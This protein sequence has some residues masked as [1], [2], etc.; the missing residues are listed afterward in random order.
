ME[1]FLAYT[2]LGVALGSVYAIAATG[3]V[4]TY[5]T[6]GIFNFAHGAIGMLSGLFYWQLRIGWDWPAPLAIVATVFVFAPAVG[7]LL[8]FLVMRH[9]QGTSEVTRLVVPVA[10]LLALN[11]AATWVWFRK[12][13]VSHN[14]VEF[15]GDRKVSVFGQPLLWHQIIGMAAAA[16][17]AVALWAFLYHTRLGVTMRATVDDRALLML[18]GGRPDRMS[19]ASWAIGAG[20]AGLAGVLLSPQLGELQVFALTLLVFDA[21]PAAIAGRL[22]S[23]PLAY[24]GAIALGLAKLYFDWLSQA[25]SRWPAFGNL[26]IALPA[27]LLFVVLLILPQERLRGAV[28][29]RTREEFRVPTLG[30][31]LLWGGL[32]ILGVG[33]LQAVMHD[34]AVI[35]LANAMGLALMALSLVLLTGY[36][37][38]VNLAVF[39]F[40]GI[41]LIAMWQFEVGPGGT[42]T[43]E[44]MSLAG[45]ALAM[46]VC[47]VVGGLIALPALRLRGLYL[48][49]ATFAFAIV[50]TQLVIFQINPLHFEILG[51]RFELNLF[52]T[53]SLT[54]P[55]PHWFGIDFA[56]S[57]RAYLMLMTALFS[58]LGVALVALRRSSYGRV[59]AAMKDSPAACATLGLNIVRMKLSVFMLSSALAGLGGLMWAA[60]QRQLSNQGSFDVFVSLS[61]FMLTVVGGIGYVSGAL[62][63][64]VFMSVLG[65]VIPDIFHKLGSDYPTLDWL[66]EGALGNFTK[67]LGPA[68]L[69]I[70]LGRHPA[71]VASQLMD[72]FRP[73]RR[74]PGGVA[75]W[76]VGELLIWSLAWR[77]VIGN[78]TFA[79]LT[80]AG[81]FVVPRLIM[82]ADRARFAE[83][84]P[85]S[86]AEELD[87]LGLERPFTVADRER[88]DS[89]LGLGLVRTE[90]GSRAVARMS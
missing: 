83:V 43:R 88:L 36:A 54:V 70:G 37:G 82:A 66:F 5:S 1:D 38:E 72:G 79:I 67:Y 18:N 53:G 3:L 77:G 78:W 68:L 8:D 23:V 81:F 87:H 60:Q 33:F 31:A 80:I 46:A 45:I 40:A 64:G 13:G 20:L 57:Q 73:L 22:K 6:S 84:L 27:L 89:A 19:V 65:V 14:P 35:A 48:G 29:T 10:V 42:A 9:L 4:V 25:G 15:F 26:R 24:V 69:G 7:A 58:V 41:A 39:T 2:V 71:G 51:R 11:G 17:V 75:A 90:I 12:P 74:S 61:L 16:L 86:E 55:R 59:L 52:S 56:A 47:A 28:L 85:I 49:L 30:Q 21:Y 44:S 76:V 62:L 32:L 63:A 34:S 50:V